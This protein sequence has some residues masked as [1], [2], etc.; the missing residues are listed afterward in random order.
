MSQ[1][2]VL[3]LSAGPVPPDVPQNFTTDAGSAVPVANN[4]NVFGGT[5]IDTSGAGDTITISFDITES[6]TIAT[7]YT[8][9]AGVAVPALNNLNVVG[10]AGITT[11]GAGDILTIALTGGGAGIDSFSTDLAG[12]VVPD[13]AG[14]VAV[15]GGQVF[16]DGTIPNTLRLSVEATA[17]TLL[18]GNG[19][20]VAM[21]EIGP[22]TDGQ[23]IIG[24]TGVPPV[25]STLTQGAG[26]TIVNGAGT[27]TISADQNDTMT[28][29]AKNIGFDLTAGVFSITGSDGTALSAANPGYVTMWRREATDA[30]ELVTVTLTANQTFSDNASGGSTIA[31][32]LFGL[33][34]TVNYG[35]NLPFFVYAVLNDAETTVQFMI[36]R[37]NFAL[38]SPISADIGMPS[39]P[40]ADKQNDFFSFANITAADFE[41]NPAMPIGTIYM[42]K[43]AGAANDWT[44]Q[45]LFAS[46]TGI[47]WPGEFYG[48]NFGENFSVP[49]G[50]F[51]AAT[52]TY[53]NA[54]GG[55]APIF[56]TNSM[57]FSFTAS[58]T[59]RLAF[60]MDADGG[61]D[62]AGAVA[63]QIAI[64]YT[65]LVDTTPNSSIV[66][67]GYLTCPAYTGLVGLELLGN[68]R[69]LTIRDINGNLVANQDFS[70]GARTLKGQVN[71]R[72]GANP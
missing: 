14:N 2:G 29:G 57:F 53:I 8:A 32:N 33:T 59:V 48:L 19:N 60:Y 46:A 64:P 50:Q 20:N 49:T 1:A 13:G 6:P 40:V 69:Y 23:V 68:T 66:G 38:T 21:S 51:G 71:F 62:G 61:T 43:V 9:D 16:S 41:G 7:S 67:T 22:L 37:A 45:G 4:L 5:S 39:T 28:V 27:I 24:S 15:T 55:T 12:P 70:N 10:G 34:D 54:N 18:Y 17:N 3:N 36:S 63:T 31:G 56:T 42:R 25:A 11:T 65:G 47:N 72:T 35:N 26:I 30:G 44:V 52:S 58:N